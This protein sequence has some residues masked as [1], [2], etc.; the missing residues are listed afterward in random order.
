MNLVTARM[1][2]VSI[3]YV[4]KLGPPNPLFLKLVHDNW[5]AYKAHIPLACALI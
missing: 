5:H 3:W 4:A 1:S 2:E